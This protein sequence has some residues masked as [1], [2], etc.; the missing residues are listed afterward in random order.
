MR[1]RAAVVACLVGL[2]ALLT[3]ASDA[4]A[5]RLDAQVTVSPARKVQV[6][7]WFSNGDVPRAAKVEIFTADGRPLQTGTLDERGTFTFVAD[8]VHGM[9][10][11]VSAGAG[12]RKELDVTE[13]QLKPT[14][15][16]D[17]VRVSSRETGAPLRDVLS[18]LAFVLGLA[19]FVVSVRN[20]QKLRKLAQIQADRKATTVSSS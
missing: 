3:A 18:G 11:V 5:H 12:H 17:S 20:A 2:P 10:V 7:S 14:R 4:R 15:A 19:A 8:A 16:D 6:E 13:D 9:R 1:G